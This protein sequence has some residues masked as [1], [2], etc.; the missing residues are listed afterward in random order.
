MKKLYY[1]NS[2]INRI[3]INEILNPSLLCNKL[4]LGEG[5]TG[6]FNFINLRKNLNCFLTDL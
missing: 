5:L 4:I 2:S 6:K 3:R 1:K